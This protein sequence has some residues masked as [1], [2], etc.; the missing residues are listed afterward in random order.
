[1]RSNDRHV[2][3]QARG[4]CSA[5]KRQANLHCTLRRRLDTHASIPE[6]SSSD[7]ILLH[8]RAQQSS[9]TLRCR[10]EDCTGTCSPGIRQARPR[11]TLVMCQLHEAG[12]L[13]KQNAALVIL[14][15]RS[16]ASGH[17]RECN[18]GQNWTSIGLSGSGMG[19]MGGLAFQ[20]LGIASRER[21]SLDFG[22]NSSLV[23]KAISHMFKPSLAVEV[24][25]GISRGANPLRQLPRNLSRASRPCAIF[26]RC[27]REA[28]A[29]GSI[30]RATAF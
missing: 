15:H 18:S 24:A 16:A 17:R 29:S 10:M 2:P 25:A 23:R 12:M 8:F 19:P 1:M 30:G 11:G 14:T 7:L 6:K 26:V 5:Q 13:R 27:R 21:M 9:H 3:Q 28:W 22:P 4:V 20:S